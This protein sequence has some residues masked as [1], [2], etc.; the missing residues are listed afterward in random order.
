MYTETFA[1]AARRL[2]GGIWMS[3][4]VDITNARRAQ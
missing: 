3:A 2:V 4:Q 1:E